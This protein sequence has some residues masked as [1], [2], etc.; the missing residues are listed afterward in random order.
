MERDIFR[1]V[2]LTN[3]LPFKTYFP[4]VYR[5]QLFIHRTKHNKVNQLQILEL[6]CR[7]S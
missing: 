7:T 4:N 3:Q 5:R 2:K 6:P 1:Y